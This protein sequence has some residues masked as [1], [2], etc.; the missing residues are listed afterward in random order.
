MSVRDRI[1]DTFVQA[2]WERWYVNSFTVSGHKHREPHTIW[3]HLPLFAG[4]FVPLQRT[5]SDNEC[6]PQ[7]GHFSIGFN[8]R[9]V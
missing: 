7:F 2:L 5:T 1:C 4:M 6:S 8:P 3:Y 9:H